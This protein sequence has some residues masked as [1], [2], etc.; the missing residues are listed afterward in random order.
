MKKAIILIVFLLVA[1][2]VFGQEFT[3]RGLPWGSS[4]EDIIAKEGKPDSNTGS[5]LIYQNIRIA[6]YNNAALLFY[7]SPP[8]S[9]IYSEKIGLQTA[10]YMLGI[11]KANSEYVYND[12]LS[13]LST[14]YGTPTLEIRPDY[15]ISNR[16]YYWIVSRTKIT[17]RLIV[18]F[19]MN[20]VQGSFIF[21]DY[22]SPDSTANEFSDL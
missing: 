12:L 18:D 22:Y 6:G 8:R 14:L 16:Y 20:D 7:C 15:E 3:F 10:K 5:Q 1:G 21:I 9:D 2:A 4:V 19:K 13:K 11:T 17:L